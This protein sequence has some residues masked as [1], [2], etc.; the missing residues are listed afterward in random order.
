[1]KYIFTLLA[2]LLI[3]STA[4]ANR[5]QTAALFVEGFIRGALVEDIGKI[6]HCISD[7]ET[8]ISDV[9]HIVHDAEDGPDILGMV[10]DV[11]KLLTHI[12]SGVKDCLQVPPAVEK[13]LIKWVNELKDSASIGQILLEALSNHGKEIAD[14]TQNFLAQWKNG[15]PE[16]AGEALG[17]IPHILFDICGPKEDNEVLPPLPINPRD[18]GYFLSGFLSSALGKDISGIETCLFPKLKTMKFFLLSQSTQE[19]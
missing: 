16:K 13:T 9:L 3:C 7:V 8:I 14:D 6:D 5:V 17:D 18:V 11:G 2:I 15:N 19:T 4:S 10:S 12:P 1:M